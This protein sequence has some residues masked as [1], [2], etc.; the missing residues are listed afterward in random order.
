M[1]ERHMTNQRGFTLLEVLVS[2]VVLAV[3]LLGVGKLLM[4]AVKADDS[5][6]M[7]TQATALAYAILDQMRAN[8]GSA[9]SQNYDVPFGPFPNPGNVCLGAGGCAANALAQYDLYQWKR[10]L[11][12]ALPA[13]DG[14]VVTATGANNQTSATVTVQWND[15]LA[16]LAFKGA[17]ANPAPNMSVTL[18][19]VL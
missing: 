5:A 15:S 19:S 17:E 9:V 4:G 8:H 1:A 12:G 2:L 18:N 14:T 13:G 16:Q 6:H 11:L 7:R 10:S 3:G